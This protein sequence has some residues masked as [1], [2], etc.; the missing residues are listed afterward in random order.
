GNADQA[1]KY[2]GSLRSAPSPEM[3]I[4]S[5]YETSMVQLSKGDIETA[6]K[7]LQQIVGLK[8]TSAESVRLKNL[9]KAGLA[10][11]LAR[12]D[13]QGESN[14]LINEMIETLNPADT[15]VAARIYNAQGAAMEAAGDDE[16]AIL[17]YLHT[18]LMFSSDAESHV[19]ALRRLADLWTRVGK[20]DRAAQARGELQQR[21]PGLS[22]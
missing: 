1:L 4:Q 10:V 21:Y 12:G 2:Y 20:P 19:L 3:K 11:A 15:V 22:G 5:V 16:G 7:Q 8:V 17:A 9:A 13:K 6:Q 14:Q 18:H